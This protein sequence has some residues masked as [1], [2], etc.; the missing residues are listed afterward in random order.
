M[1]TLRKQAERYGAELISAG[2]TAVDL[3]G[4]AKTA[5]LD[6]QRYEAKTNHC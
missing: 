2:V 6:D 4:S 3:T 5:V 1:E